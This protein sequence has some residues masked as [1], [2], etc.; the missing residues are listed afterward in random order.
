MLILF[1]SDSS[2]QPKLE[3]VSI[4][5]LSEGETVESS[6]VE[7]RIKTEPLTVD[8]I[9]IDGVELE[10]EGFFSSEYIYRNQFKEGDNSIEI[11]IQ[12]EDQE[13]IKNIDFVVDLTR[14]KLLD[15]LVNNPVPYDK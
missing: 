1:A 13:I 5:S 2:T 9:S 7:V 6:E 10:K 3:I 8:S 12:D 11:I 4:D 14:Q 15:S